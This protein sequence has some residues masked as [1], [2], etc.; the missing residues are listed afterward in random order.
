M[1]SPSSTSNLLA[2]PLGSPRIREELKAETTVIDFS[3]IDGSE[4]SDGSIDFANVTT[5]D[6]RNARYGSKTSMSS[7]ASNAKKLKSRRPAQK[8]KH[9]KTPSRT[10]L[11]VPP[12]N[13][14]LGRERG[15]SDA[16]STMS[17]TPNFYRDISIYSEENSLYLPREVNDPVFTAQAPLEIIS[18]FF[19]VG[20]EGRDVSKS[21]RERD[22]PED[23]LIPDSGLGF[24]T[25][26]ES[27]QYDASEGTQISHRSNQ[28]LSSN[29]LTTPRTSNT[30][31]DHSKSCLVWELDFEGPDEE[32]KIEYKESNVMKHREKVGNSVRLEG[33]VLQKGSKA[34]SGRDK[35]HHFHSITRDSNEMTND[36]KLRDWSNR[37]KC[38]LEVTGTVAGPLETNSPKRGIKKRT[39]S[40]DFAWSEANEVARV[41]V[42]ELRTPKDVGEYLTDEIKVED[43]GFIDPFL[44]LLRGVLNSGRQ[45]KIT[46]RAMMKKKAM[47]DCRRRQ[48]LATLPWKP[49]S[50]SSATLIRAATCRERTPPEKSFCRRVSTIE[51]EETVELAMYDE[52]S[53]GHI[54]SVQRSSKYV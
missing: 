37:E 41:L 2:T 44:H 24:T 46:S 50:V 15:A 29:I 38:F 8:K 26:F 14:M 34:Q 11:M 18:F 51:E 13:L 12:T 16:I 28:S 40:T 25:T 17:S 52:S 42:S 21:T 54:R 7:T 31:L 22:L 32:K 43:S 30:H 19:Q 35:E 39:R 6:R 1:N 3:E 47:R 23:T 4:Y 49:D 20:R 9:S 53:A 45:G 10:S 36:V 48:K 5:R 27:I 33:I